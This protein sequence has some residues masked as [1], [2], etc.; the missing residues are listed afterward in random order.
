MKAVSSGHVAVAEYLV[1][2]GVD[3][4]FVDRVRRGCDDLAVSWLTACFARWSMLGRKSGC[5][6]LLL[7]LRLP[8]SNRRFAMVESLAD[9]GADM[10][11]VD[12]VRAYCVRSR[13]R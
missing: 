6:S 4:N 8:T 12:S 13:H 9:R 10:N 3:V 7:A 1:D 2:S 11:A 5:S